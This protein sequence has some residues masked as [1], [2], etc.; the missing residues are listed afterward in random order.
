MAAVRVSGWRVE[1]RRVGLAGALGGTKR[2][3]L[4]IYDQMTEVIEANETIRTANPDKSE[5]ELRP[6]LRNYQSPLNPPP[7]P[8]T[9]ANGNFIP[10]AD[11]TDEIHRRYEGVIHLSRKSPSRELN[12]ASSDA[13]IM[14]LSEDPI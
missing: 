8:P 11:W 7:G 14:N 4:E 10:Y 6:L 2:V 1:A 5:D 12:S 3:I 13:T 9:D